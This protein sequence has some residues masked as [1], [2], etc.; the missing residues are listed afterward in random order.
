[1][2]KVLSEAR[3]LQTFTN[4]KMLWLPVMYIDSLKSQEGLVNLQS[5]SLWGTIVSD[6]ESLKVLTNLNTL[7]LSNTQVIDIQPI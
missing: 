2:P 7:D 3:C 1:M 5:L 4:I 6:P